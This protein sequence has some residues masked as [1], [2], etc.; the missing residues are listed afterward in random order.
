MIRR[1]SVILA[2]GDCRTLFLTNHVY[3]VYEIYNTPTNSLVSLKSTTYILP[4]YLYD[5]LK[6][7]YS[8]MTKM[9]TA[10]CKV[11]SSLPISDI[12][13]ITHYTDIVKQNFALQ[14]QLMLH[15]DE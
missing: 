15:S 11:G 12:N 10:N 8:A 6:R 13:H 2:S 5:T 3:N 9:L 1:M 14:S 4:V 7:L